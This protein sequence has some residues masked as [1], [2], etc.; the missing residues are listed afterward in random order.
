MLGLENNDLSIMLVGC[1]AIGLLVTGRL[2]AM[3]TGWLLLGAVLAVATVGTW[4]HLAGHPRLARRAMSEAVRR[5]H[6][7]AHDYSLILVAQVSTSAWQ[8]CRW[9]L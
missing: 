3:L 9:P 2:R 6:S 7:S 1:L 4:P 5:E 8:R